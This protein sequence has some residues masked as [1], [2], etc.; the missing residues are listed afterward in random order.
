MSHSKTDEVSVTCFA[1]P[2]D[3]TASFFLGTEEG[4]IYPANRYDRSGGKAGID[5]QNTFSVPVSEV[6]DMNSETVNQFDIGGLNNGHEAMVTGLS[7]HPSHPSYL[8]TSSLDWTVRLWDTKSRQLLKMFDE[9][10]DYVMDVSW[11]PTHASMFACI[12]ASGNVLLYNLD[13]DPEVPI[14]TVNVAGDDVSARAGGGLNGGNKLSWD[15]YGRHIAVA[16]DS[17]VSVYS[18]GDVASSDTIFSPGSL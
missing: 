16:S 15:R 3:E 2:P 12:D 7:I 1:F 5:H 17:V 4:G 10:S 8:L 14:A 13:E 6:A 9:C 18:I 11:S